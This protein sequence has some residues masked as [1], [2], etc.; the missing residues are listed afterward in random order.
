MDPLERLAPRAGWLDRFRQSWFPPAAVVGA[1]AAF[2]TA[3]WR[4]R[5]AQREIPAPAG[6]SPAAR[7]PGQPAVS[8]PSTR[9]LERQYARS[10]VLGALGSPYARSLAGIAVS[11]GDTIWTLGDDEIRAFGPDG[12]FIRSWK[13]PQRAACLTAGPDGRVYVGSRGR[14]DIYDEGGS[15]VS[16]FPAGSPSKPGFMTSIKVFQDEILVGDAGARCI[17]R[18][19]PSGRQLGEIGTQ[20]KTRGFMLPNGFLDFAVDARGVIRA[21]DSG[22]HRVTAWALDGSPLGYF[23][24]FGQTSPEDFTGC[25]NPVNLAVTPDGKVVTGEKAGAR[26]KVYEPDGTLLAMIGPEHF[27]AAC[28]HVHLAVDSKGRILAAD[29][30]RRQVKVFSL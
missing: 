3:A 21:T 2:T 13:L 14:V 9:K 16:D 22:R 26:V 7:P 29:P 8:A 10:A 30:V 23:G 25:C 28:T 20:N 5:P 12:G 6:S 15:L 1:F 17:R 24:K 27:D 4:T 18:Y 19:T 11:S